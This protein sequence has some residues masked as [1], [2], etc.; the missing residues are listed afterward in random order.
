M[1]SVKDGLQTGILQQVLEMYLTKQCENLG[2]VAKACKSAVRKGIKFLS[3]Q[4]QK[5][6]PEETCKVSASLQSGHFTSCMVV[7][8]PWISWTIIYGDE[9]TPTEI[10][11]ADLMSV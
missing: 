8:Q 10:T 9:S 3:D 7:L 5:M 2:V 1:K 4:V 6:K 11:V